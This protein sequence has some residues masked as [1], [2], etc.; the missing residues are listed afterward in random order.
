M[1]GHRTLGKGVCNIEAVYAALQA[2]GFDGYT[3]LEIAGEAAVLESY[4]FLK[5][6]GAE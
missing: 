1:P 3:T 4:R 2:I 6:L 5:E